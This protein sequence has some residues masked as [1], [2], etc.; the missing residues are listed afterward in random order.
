MTAEEHVVAV[1][2]ERGRVR[3][4]CASPS[5]AELS[6]VSLPAVRSVTYTQAVSDAVRRVQALAGRRADDAR[7]VV[8]GASRASLVHSQRRRRVPSGP[9][10]RECLATSL[11]YDLAT[12]VVVRTATALAAL[13]EGYAGLAAGAPDG[14]FVYINLGSYTEIC[15]VEN[16]EV[17]REAAALTRSDLDLEGAATPQAVQKVIELLLPFLRPFVVTP[18]V[19][20][21]RT[22]PR[23]SDD[24]DAIWLRTGFVRYSTLRPRLMTAEVSDS[25]VLDGALLLSTGRRER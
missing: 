16:G 7:R 6:R 1:H 5:G 24:S 19:I 2:V 25:K 23:R 8:V 11:E 21:T 10:W 17:V 4:V 3:A 13:V 12:S 22:M 14:R 20:V 9:Y 15:M 18:P